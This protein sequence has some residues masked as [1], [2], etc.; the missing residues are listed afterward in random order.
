MDVVMA[1]G[2]QVRAMIAA[3]AEGGSAVPASEDM[4][5]R[6]AAACEPTVSEEGSAVEADPE[7][8]DTETAAGDDT[9]VAPV[10]YIEENDKELLDIFLQQLR[11]ELADLINSANREGHLVEAVLKRCQ[12]QVEGLS[13][14]ANY[15]GYT[16]LLQAYTEWELHLDEQLSAVSQGAAIQNEAW[17][18]DSVLPFVKSIVG[19]FPQADVLA[20]LWEDLDLPAETVS[21]GTAETAAVEPVNADLLSQLGSAFDAM[22]QASPTSVAR[23]PEGIEGELFSAVV[24]E[25]GDEDAAFID[26][27]TEDAEADVPLA[28]ADDLGMSADAV[29]EAEPAP[30]TGDE[31]DADALVPE[32]AETEPFS[33]ATSQSPET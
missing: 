31:A 28:V 6:L 15:M 14:S 24:A 25:S 4:L 19:F 3:Q 13:S 7:Q 18:S 21:S 23:I 1:A 30:I 20:S 27:A 9:P 16:E 5:L 26:P 22:L 32:S 10:N 8:T 33:S 17:L 12:E 11:E 29:S 2:D